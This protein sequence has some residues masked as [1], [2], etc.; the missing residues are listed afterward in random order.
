MNHHSFWNRQV[1][2]GVASFACVGSATQ[3]PAQTPP[4]SALSVPSKPTTRNRAEIAPQYKWDFMAIYPSWEAWEAAM[5]EMQTKM[6]AF[7]ALK[8]TLAH[9]PQAIL[10]A[11]RA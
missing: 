9:G 3:L 7:A 6:D 8:G 1:L 5:K 4:P 10:T 2:M 11:Y